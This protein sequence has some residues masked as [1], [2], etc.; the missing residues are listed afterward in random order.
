LLRC[1]FVEDADLLLAAPKKRTSEETGNSKE[2]SKIGRRLVGH[3]VTKYQD[4]EGL[5]PNL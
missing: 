2:G 3:E 1:H 5:K 4:V